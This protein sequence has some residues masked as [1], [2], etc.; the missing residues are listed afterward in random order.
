M[1]KLENIKE[2][3]VVVDMINGFVNTGALSDTYINHITEENVRLVKKFIKDEEREVAFIRDAHKETSREFTKFPSHCVTGTYESEL[4]SELKTYEEF[5]RTYLKNSRSAM[6]AECFMSDL[7][8]MRSLRE[9]II[10]GCCT[11]LCVLDLAL[12][13]VNYLDEKDKNIDVIV[14]M[15]A[16]ETYDSPNHKREDYNELAFKLM[17]QEGIKLVKKL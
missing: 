8:K 2:L 15:N 11:D 13:L 5:A 1:K 16:V 9:I 6:F 12:P 10:T 14:P 7:E 17:A 4:I 3:L